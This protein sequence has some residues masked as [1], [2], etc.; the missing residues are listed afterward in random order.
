VPC[1]STEETI[2]Q[3]ILLFF[4][5]LVTVVLRAA[6]IAKSSL[7]GRALAQQ[8]L[9]GSTF[10]TTFLMTLL[11]LQFSFMLMLQSQFLLYPLFDLVCLA[12]L[13]LSRIN[14]QLLGVNQS[15]LQLGQLSIDSL[16]LCLVC[17]HRRVLLLS[18]QLFYFSLDVLQ[19]K[20]YFL[21]HYN[22]YKPH[23]YPRD[24]FPSL[25]ISFPSHP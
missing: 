2:G 25:G 10:K 5:L 23:L 14:N 12:L 24:N 21:A 4:A 3:G 15:L 19:R 6:L 13:L 8:M 17:H 9:P 20:V 16:S 1:F 18:L 7:S 22:N 11:V